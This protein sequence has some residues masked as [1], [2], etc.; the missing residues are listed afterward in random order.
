MTLLN[1]YSVFD[2]L[3]KETLRLSQE[4]VQLIK[5]V[6]TRASQHQ[7]FDHFE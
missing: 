7:D 5:E 4:Q 2:V 6:S 1:A 3:Y